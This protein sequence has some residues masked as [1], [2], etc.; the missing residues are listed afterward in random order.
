MQDQLTATYGDLLQGS[1]DCPDRIV[2]NAYFR[3]GYSPGGFRHWWRR[4]HGSDDNLD[5]S[6]LMRMAGRFGRRL[7]AYAQQH[8]I[9]VEYCDADERKHELAEQYLPEDPAFTGLFLVIVSRATGAVWD[10]KETA[11]GRIHSLDKKYRFINHYFFHIVDPQ[12]GHVTIRVSGHPPFG[13]MVILNGHEYVARQASEAGLE[14]QQ[15]SNC[16]VQ[17]ANAAALTQIAETL[18]DPHIEGQ[19]RQVCERWLYTTCLHF[20]LPEDE[21]LRSGFHYEYS[22]FQVEFRRNLLFQRG[23]QMEQIFQA[24]IDRSRSRLN[25]KRVKTIFGYKRRPHRKGRQT[26]QP[27]LEI[28]IERPRYDLTIFK[29]NF[30]AFTVK[31]YTKGET[32]LRAETIVHQAKALQCPR[33]L[34]NF[35]LIVTKL[36]QILIRFLDQLHCL[37]QSFVADETLDTL[38]WPGFVGQCRT[39]GI[40][41]NKSRLRAVIEAVVSLATLPNGFTASQLAD[42]VRAILNYPEEQYRTRHASYDLKKL[43]GKAWVSKIGK[44]RRYQ[45]DPTGLKTMA[46]LLS[47]RDKV[48]KPVLAGAGKPKSGPKPKFQTELDI[49]YAK[50]QTEMRSLLLLLGVAV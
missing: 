7:K 21:Q 4:L 39:A 45:V 46:A 42:K 9:P 3:M 49:Q 2:L 26:H 32:V 20:A 31:L 1:Y 38:G 19:L 28:V 43:R 25:L 27:R 30:G 11:D 35:S 12:W 33:S 16:F 29:I 37:D 15:Q 34:H 40:D 14:F 47:L 23:A 36:R 6:H 10:V 41:L 18:C 8:D 22:V 13:A 44:S 5:K 17:M 24:I 48:I 50:V